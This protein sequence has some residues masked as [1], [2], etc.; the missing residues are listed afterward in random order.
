MLKHIIVPIIIDDHEPEKC[1]AACQYWD[2]YNWICT[3]YDVGVD[4][5]RQRCKRCMEEAK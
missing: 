3:L 1:G 2:G 4:K 5:P